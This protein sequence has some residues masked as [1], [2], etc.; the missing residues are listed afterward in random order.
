[1]VGRT[2]QA[3]A[4]A[5]VAA[6]LSSRTLVWRHCDV[7]RS[8]YTVSV[9]PSSPVVGVGPSVCR[10]SVGSQALLCLA[11]SHSSRFH[12]S[13]SFLFRQL[14]RRRHGF[15]NG[16]GVGAMASKTTYPQNVVSPRFSATSFCRQTTLF[17]L[18]FEKTGETRNFRG[19]P[20]PAIKS[21]RVRDPP[22]PP[23]PV[24]DASASARL[25]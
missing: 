23:P 13:S 4:P 19:G 17:M 3:R 11:S 21:A 24:G 10:S 7:K 9:S 1:M 20:P 25:P 2:T 15:S 5:W 6:S 22:P 16:G 12:F 14:P 18:I 8:S